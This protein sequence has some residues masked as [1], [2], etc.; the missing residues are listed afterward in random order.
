MTERSGPDCSRATT[1]THCAGRILGAPR[2]RRGCA[3]G[4]PSTPAAA[5]CCPRCWWAPAVRA[6]AGQPARHAGG[7]GGRGAARRAGARRCARGQWARNL[8][9]VPRLDP[10]APDVS[11]DGTRA[12]A[13]RPR[14]SRR[15]SA[16][17]RIPTAFRLQHVDASASTYTTDWGERL[18]ELGLGHGRRRTAPDADGDPPD[19]FDDPAG[20]GTTPPRVNSVLRGDWLI[21]ATTVVEQRP[22]APDDQLDALDAYAERERPRDDPV[23]RRA[24]TTTGGASYAQESLSTSSQAHGERTEPVALAARPRAEHHG[25]AGRARRAGGVL[26]HPATLPV[27]LG[28]AARRARDA[29]RPTLE[30]LRGWLDEL[31]TTLDAPPGARRATTTPKPLPLLRQLLAWSIENAT[32]ADDQAGSQPASQATGSPTLLGLA[33]IATTAADPV[34]EL[35][36]LMRE[37]LGAYAVPA[38]RLV[39]RRRRLAPREQAPGDGRAG[40]R[41]A[42]SAGS[43]N[44][45]PRETEAA[46]QGYVLAP[47]LTHATT[48]AILRSGWSAFGGSAESAGLAVDLSSDRIRRARWLVDGVRA[49]QDLGRL[50][51]ARFERG[52]QTR[53]RLDEWIDDLRAARARGRRERRGPQR[54]R[55]RPAA[56]ARLV[57]TTDERDGDSMPSRPPRTARHAAGRAPAA[58]RHGPRG[59]ARLARRPTSMRSPTRRSRRASSRSP[60]ATSPR[61]PRR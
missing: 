9:D 33:A 38:R 34:G 4:A 17:S 41:S 51:G 3:T 58:T 27:G 40:S 7:A 35:E 14:G 42:P 22:R 48:A 10:D 30:E 43:T 53:R 55:R 61:R 56:R 5:A 49:G 19:A 24:T 37:T 2:P 50:L 36:R 23:H 60:R 20:S 11:A 44:V 59:G 31:A 18:T 28:A 25:D 57:A 13:S 46:S 54:D 1:S 6:P 8:L 15:S 45:K 32:D 26:H 52:L 29:P 39:H 47:S 12:R 21:V 16:P